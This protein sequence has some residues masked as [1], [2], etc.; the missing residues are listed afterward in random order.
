MAKTVEQHFVTF[1]SPGTFLA[2]ETTKP[3]K[4]WDVKQAKKMADNITGRY[5][6][7][8]YGF[9][10]T[11]RARGENDLDSKD[12]MQSPMYF[13]PHCRVE[14]LAEVK[15]RNDP[16]DRILVSNM[17]GNVYKKIVTTTRGWK[18]TQP[19]REGDV[20]LEA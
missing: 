18:W 11:T 6:A 10:F 2:E 5:A 15:R 17:E 13:L 8:P 12:I 20:L 3:I 9:Y 7:F 4:S 19:F 14:T 16:K 1:V